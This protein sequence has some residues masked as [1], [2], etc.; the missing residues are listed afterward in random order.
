MIDFEII[1][2]LHP[3]VP[4]IDIERYSKEEGITIDNNED[5]L[6]QLIE[7][8]CC[9]G[10]TSSALLEGLLSYSIP[11]S[12]SSGCLK[13]SIAFEKNKVGMRLE[14]KT[15]TI[16]AILEL[17][18]LDVVYKIYLNNIKQQKK[19]LFTK[20]QDN[21]CNFLEKLEVRNESF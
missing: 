11:I 4:L 20:R 21:L 16:D 7:S 1:C 19:Y 3:S 6:D 15:E 12:F 14:T 17:A 10:I 2:R 13:H 9:V 5:I 8:I 18:K